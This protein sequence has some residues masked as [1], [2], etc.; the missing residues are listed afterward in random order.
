MSF[1]TSLAM[2][3]DPARLF[4]VAT[5]HTTDPWQARLLRSRAS[6]ILLNCC[7]QSGK[8]TSTAAL[9]LHTALYEPGSLTLLLSPSLRQSQELYRK[10]GAQYRALGRPVAPVSETLT[11]L[12][13]A[14]ES[15]IVSLPENEETLRGFSGV[16]LL[17]IDEAARVADEVY[18][19]VTPM[20]AVSRGRLLALSTPW[21]KLGWWHQAWTSGGQRWERYE[22]PATMCPR[23]DAATLDE[24]RLR[25]DWFYLQEYMCQF[26]ERED[27]V[28]NY[29]QV[30]R[31]ICD[32]L[33]PFDDVIP[34]GA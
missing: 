32:E 9:A 19:A 1:K 25:G 17:V 12:E 30:T 8:S 27:A 24:A 4:T 26:G 34:I 23:I 14:N 7:R 2:A 29:E 33:E 21:G 6:R 3:L 22:V 11:H 13:L 31:A 15:R 5:R 20:L 18:D 10:V 16:R 28:F